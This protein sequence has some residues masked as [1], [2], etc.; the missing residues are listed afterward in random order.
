[1]SLAGI[2]F[3]RVQMV[4]FDVGG[5]L[6]EPYPGVGHVYAEI[7]LQSGVLLSPFI[8]DKRFQEIFKKLRANP[9]R[10]EISEQTAQAFWREI[11]RHCIQPEC[12][13]AQVQDVFQELWFE[14]SQARRWRALPGAG[15][16]LAALAGSRRKVAV[17]SNWDARLRK[18]L[19][20]LDW[21][22]KLDGIFISSELG[23]EKPDA[24][25]F[26]AV[27]E[28]LQLPASACLHVGDSY[29]QDYDAAR[30]AGWQAALYSIQAPAGEPAIPSFN[31]LNDLI[32][33]LA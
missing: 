9:A 3:A 33:Y 26:R 25:V 31:S 5:T 13:A 14:F 11:V 19:E 22:R 12:P 32:P 27:E 18:V 2:D 8:I 17:L 7:L 15:E 21:E 4:T 28:A 30:A 24:R 1:M 23:A 6:L 10:R 16:L 20:E 29:A